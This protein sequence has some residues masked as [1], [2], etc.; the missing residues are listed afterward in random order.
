LE[1]RKAENIELAVRNILESS[2]AKMPID[3][4]IYNIATTLKNET[5]FSRAS[6]YIDAF[7]LG[8]S[9]QPGKAF[10][11]VMEA[12]YK[13]DMSNDKVISFQDQRGTFMAEAITKQ[14]VCLN[15]SPQ[16][17]VAFINVPVG[18][19]A[20]I[21]LSNDLPSDP[22]H[23]YESLNNIKRIFPSLSLLERR[24][25]DIGFQEGAALQK[26]R[27]KKGDG[28]WEEELGSIFLDINDYSRIADSFG[29]SF[30]RFIS[31]TYVPALIK[32]L[33]GSAVSEH[34]AG[35]E[36]YFIII[37]DLLPPGTLIKGAVLECLI[38][39]DAFVEVS[40]SEMCISHGFPPV[41]ASIGVNIGVGTIISDSVSV[42]TTGNVVNHAKR[43][44]EESGKGGILIKDGLD[45][46]L[47]GSRFSLGEL[48][49]IQKK[50]QVIP[51]RRLLRTREADTKRRTS[52]GQGEDRSA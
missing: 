40:G 36:I 46:D 22:Y 51:A 2:E 50:K 8:E 28:R 11:R 5:R 27:L 52:K 10:L 45:L 33:S 12:G 41:S 49:I 23:A 38:K 29:D 24:L 26:L 7:C 47:S 39:I 9:K 15:F 6:A 30:T 31:D 14:N 13:K 35:D 3:A 17:G 37:Q 34:F 1:R 44:Q 20:C 32:T 16:T 19:H 4:I 25:I 21:N 42:R 43:L 48:V 18:R